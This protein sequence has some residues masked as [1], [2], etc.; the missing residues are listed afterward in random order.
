[1][2]DPHL[3]GIQITDEGG[4][5]RNVVYPVQS[6]ATVAQIQTFVDAHLDKLDNVVGGLV[7]GAF[8]TLSLSIGGLAQ[9]KGAAVAD[10][11]VKNGGLLGFT[12]TGTKYRA[13]IYVPS[14]LG[15][16]IDAQDSIADAGATAVLITSILS[17]EANIS[18]CDLAGRDLVSFLGGNAV[19]RK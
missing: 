19:H 10:H 3:L 17:G 16:L 7:T 11:S 9:G 15:T 13:S 1:M 14:F 2:A 12:A 4:R 6:T 8:V 18:I 5:K